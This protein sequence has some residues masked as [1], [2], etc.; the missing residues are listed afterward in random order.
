MGKLNVNAK[1]SI[2]N[3]D[4]EDCVFNVNDCFDSRD[5]HDHA[6]NCIPR[7]SLE[8]HSSS[9]DL[10][11]QMHGTTPVHSR[12]MG[13]PPRMSLQSLSSLFVM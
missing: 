10:N 6:A 11:A 1:P 2:Q 12:L 13:R 7:K 4:N 9:T 8:C 5:S 3:D